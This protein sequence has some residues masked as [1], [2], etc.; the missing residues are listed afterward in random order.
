MSEVQSP[1]LGKWKKEMKIEI[2]KFCGKV[3]LDLQ[4]D[5]EVYTSILVL[6]KGGITRNFQYNNYVL[7]LRRNRIADEDSD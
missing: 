3:F 4:D 2:T 5:R 7:S 6:S 1:A